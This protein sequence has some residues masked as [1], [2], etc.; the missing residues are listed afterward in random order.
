MCRDGFMDRQTNRLLDASEKKC[1]S[2]SE[3]RA[4]IFVVWS[5]QKYKFGKEH[6]SLASCQVL[7]NYLFSDFREVKNVKINDRQTEG[8]TTDG[9]WSQ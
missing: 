6:C 1:L 8:Q 4:A 3:A 7:S 5:A 2:Q 9:A